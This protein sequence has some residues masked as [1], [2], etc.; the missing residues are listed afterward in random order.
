[1]FFQFDDGVESFVVV[2]GGDAIECFVEQ[3]GHGE[4]VDVRA[5]AFEASGQQAQFATQFPFVC[6]GVAEDGERQI[7]IHGDAWR[8]LAQI[9]FQLCDATFE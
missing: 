1:M 6:G 5:G 2:G 9:A 8:G 3:V 7:P 4:G